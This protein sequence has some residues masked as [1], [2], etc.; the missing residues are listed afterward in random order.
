MSNR[1]S[2]DVLISLLESLKN[3]ENAEVRA[4]AARAIGSQR[5]LP[6]PAV[7]A[8]GTAIKTDPEESVRI[9][10]FWAI[11][12]SEK[13]PVETLADFLI[14]L[15]E[16]DR[17]WQRLDGIRYDANRILRRSGKR[18]TVELS[19]LAKSPEPQKREIALWALA[20]SPVT[21]QTQPTL[22]RALEDPDPSVRREA[23]RGLVLLRAN[24]VAGTVPVLVQALGDEDP[25]VSEAAGEAL[26]RLDRIR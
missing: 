10:A 21:D 16:R 17:E 11:I 1:A 4:G 8:L 18:G 19:V 2:E 26:R 3:D 12:R 6:P 13:R 23:A 25:D 9:A 15:R 20:R 5:R 24:V 22:N 14:A 7:E